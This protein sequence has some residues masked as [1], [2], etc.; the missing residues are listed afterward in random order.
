MKEIDL[1]SVYGGVSRDALCVAAT[2]TGGALGAATGMLA[3]S[4]VAGPPGAA[5][6][7]AAGL[8]YGAGLWHRSFA[9]CHPAK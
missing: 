1:S 5:V 6:G 7:L 4:A 2:E 8:V 3:G 9:V